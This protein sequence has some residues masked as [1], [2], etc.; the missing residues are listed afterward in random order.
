MYGSA[1]SNGNI[2]NRSLLPILLAGGACGRAD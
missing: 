2:H 1:M